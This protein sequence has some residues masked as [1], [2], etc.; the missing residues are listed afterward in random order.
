MMSLRSGVKLGVV[1]IGAAGVGFVAGPVRPGTQCVPDEKGV[2]REV[3]VPG[4]VVVKEVFVGSPPGERVDEVPD[5]GPMLDRSE[6]RQ[7]ALALA[8]ENE[9]LRQRARSLEQQVHDLNSAM[10]AERLAADAARVEA[11]RTALPASESP[12]M[13]RW[14]QAGVWRVLERDPGTGLVALDA[15]KVDGL[16]P[17]MRLEIFRED[18]YIARVRVVEVRDHLSGALIEEMLGE[19]VPAKGDRAIPARDS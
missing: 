3:K 5:S 4:P 16:A 18:E 10:V 15:G 1:V 13:S 7:A 11:D 2:V 12:L 9:R 6:A 19:E 17:Q 8:D 14:V